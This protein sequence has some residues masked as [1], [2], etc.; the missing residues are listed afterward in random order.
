[1]QGRD[2]LSKKSNEGEALLNRWW[3]TYIEC[4]CSPE[5][6][7][8]VLADAAKLFKSWRQ[9]LASWAAL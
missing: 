2:R 9:N 7:T 8:V 3:R 4:C 5:S 6:G 1:M